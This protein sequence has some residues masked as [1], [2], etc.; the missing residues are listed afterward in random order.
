MKT[1]KDTLRKFFRHKRNQYV[2]QN[3]TT[4]TDNFYLKY[5]QVIANLLDQTN[6]YSR[7]S[8]SEKKAINI[9]AFYPVKNEIN[10]LSIMKNL[11]SLAKDYSFSLPIVP[12]DGSKLL[13]FREYQDE[14]SLVPGAFQI[15]I[16]N[17]NFPIVYPDAL[18]VPM[19][20]FNQKKFRLGYGGGYYDTTITSLKTKKPNLLT[21]GVAFDIQE[22]E[23]LPLE[24][25]DTQLDYILTEN[26]LLH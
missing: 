22:S 11:H 26:R 12:S 21:I 4:L 3:Q 13:V 16:P 25:H 7:E 10:C 14:S 24:E 20:C 18:L 9:G 2:K 23:E 17:E 15:P 5:S 8:S 6:S 19:L 1:T